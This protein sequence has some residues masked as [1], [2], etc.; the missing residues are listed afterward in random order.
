MS[1]NAVICS[2]K[3]NVD[4]SNYMDVL[5]S[6]AYEISASEQFD[7]GESDNTVI[8][9]TPQLYLEITFLFR[10]SNPDSVTL[11]Y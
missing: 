2:F 11:S 10:E 5:T 8:R 1:L 4:L 6:E 9:S 3:R 7:S